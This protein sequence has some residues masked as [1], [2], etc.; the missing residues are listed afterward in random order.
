M[1]GVFLV[2]DVVVV[3]IILVST[4]DGPFP[5]LKGHQGQ[6]PSWIFDRPLAGAKVAHH[7]SL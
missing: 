1:A 5:D 7:H 6:S 4:Q 3:Q 2:L